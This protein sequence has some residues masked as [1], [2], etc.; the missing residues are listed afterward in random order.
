[1][2]DLFYNTS[3]ILKFII[4]RERIRQLIWILAFSLF[5][6]ALVPVFENI[7][8]TSS[9]MKVLIDT[10][11]NPVMI[12]FIGPVFVNDYYTTGSMYANYMLLF[13][14]LI[15][16][17]M[18]IFLIS[19]HTR[20]D[21]EDGRLEFIQSLPIGKFSNMSAVMILAFISNLLIGVL[22]A[23]G[24]YII[25]PGEM[26]FLG[27]FVFGASLFVIGNLFAGI[28]LFYSQITISNRTA[29]GLSF[30]T[31]F[32]F[33]ALRAVG[34]MY[35]DVLSIV[36]PLGLILKTEN[37][38]NDYFYPL[39]IIFIEYFVIMGLAFAIG[40]NRD[41]GSGIIPQKAG[42]KKASPFLRSVGTFA[43]RLLRN[44]VLIWTFVI[45]IFA[46]M[47]A[48]VFG[49]LEGY[50]DSSEMIREMF[51]IDSEFSLTEQ[52]ISLLM[53]IMAIISTI[54]VLTFLHKATSEEK[55][56]LAEE[57]LAKPVSRYKYLGSFFVIAI[58]MTI[59]FQFSTAIG[60]YGVGRYFLETLP[61]FKTFLISAM[62]YVPAILVMLSISV[63]LIGVLPRLTWLNYLY[64][65]YIVVAVY[66][67]KI[68]DLPEVLA[69]AT[70]FGN[71]IQYPM[72]E[73][74]FTS[75]WILLGIFII[76]SGI[77]FIAYR[78]RDLM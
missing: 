42:R 18:N 19:T 45:L 69:K 61:S 78:N 44:P 25:L 67:G 31:L 13:S 1:M 27:S 34:D 71:V 21:E 65:G 76:L 50:I 32:F 26:S 11:K 30:F 53:V 66:F 36:S 51:I 64:L 75:T 54:P 49:D 39:G 62:M 57:I 70:P 38:V 74:E 12:A 60:F 73:L 22:T 7:I 17:T 43:F 16:A 8:S 58:L 33:Y 47:Y 29:V 59:V 24:F 55:V 6:V 63:F 52:F 72:E 20:A 5:L 15:I 37:F 4:R 41:L 77:G 23:I 3:E 68:L 10:M 48:S 9:D 56:Q 14:V 40:R 28:T 2:K 35:I 46:S